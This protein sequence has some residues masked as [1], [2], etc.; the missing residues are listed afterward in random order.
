MAIENP[1]FYLSS[2]ESY[3]FEHSRRCRIVKS[4]RTQD[5]D[6]LFIIQI[7]PPIIAQK[8]GV[9]NK[10]IDLILVATRHKEDSINP[11]KRWPVCVHVARPLVDPMAC[12]VLTEDEYESMAWAE[13]YETEEDARL[14][15][16]E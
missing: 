11:V 8:Y 15:R 3:Q 1:D 2:T 6:D 9:G 13:L 4:V 16:V 7:D 5:R 12:E 14:K 10:D